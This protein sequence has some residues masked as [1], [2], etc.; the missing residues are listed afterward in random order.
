MINLI[1][2]IL[3]ILFAVF[4]RLLPHPANFTPIAAVALFSGTYVNKKYAVIIPIAAMLISDAFIGFYS[5]MVWVY[6]SIFIITLLGFWLS[7]HK[8]ISVVAGV[9]I[10]SSVLFFI[11]TNFGVWL[12]GYYG[13]SLAGLLQCYTM[14]IPFFRNALIGDVFYVSAM[15]GIYEL[16]CKYI[17]KENTKTE[18][19]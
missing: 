12:S 3:I 18:I 10:L 11:I 1:T 19:I 2:S 13:Y 15:F 16:I 6:G 17:T 14:A 9:T 5:G 7:K 8:K 4:S